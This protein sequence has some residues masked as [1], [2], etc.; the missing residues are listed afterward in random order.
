MHTAS[1]SLFLSLSPHH[2]LHTPFTSPSPCTSSEMSS[3]ASQL[4]A[5]TSQKSASRR[6]E[7]VVG[8]GFG[9]TA[10]GGGGSALVATESSAK[11]KATVVYQDAREASDVPTSLIRAKCYEALKKLGKLYRDP[12][13][14]SFGEL[15]ASPASLHTE[16]SLL[17]AAQ[18]AAID[19]K[20]SKLLSHLSTTLHDKLSLDV[21][22]YLIR[23]YDV[24]LRNGPELLLASLAVHDTFLFSRLL[25][26]VNVAES[27]LLFFLRPHAAPGAPPVPRGL[28]A[29][30]T[31]KDDALLN[32]ICML[33][34]GAADVHV[35]CQRGGDRGDDGD[36]DEHPDRARLQGGKPNLPRPTPPHISRVVSFAMAVVV[37]ALS[38][39]RS[40]PRASSSSSSSSSSPSVD[41]IS[42]STVRLLLPYLVDA[43]GP[44][45][46]STSCMD[47]RAFGYVLASELAG[48]GGSRG[49]GQQPALGSAGREL[50]T[51]A[52]LNGA[53]E[54]D[55][56][57]LS[58][59]REEDGKDGDESG[60]D[61]DK[62]E[63]IK[64]SLER[65]EV[66]SDAILAVMATLLQGP[67]QHNPADLLPLS[68]FRLLSKMR[69]LPAALGHIQSKGKVDVATFV[70]ALLCR[71]LGHLH[72]KQ[73]ARLAKLVEALTAVPELRRAVWSLPP[74]RS[75][76][77][78]SSEAADRLVRDLDSFFGSSKDADVEGDDA[79]P[80]LAVLRALRAVDPPGADAG[81]ARAV[82]EADGS[83]S[84]KTLAA[85]DAVVGG[86]AGSSAG[87]ASPSEQQGGA[88]PAGIPPRV[89]L[90]H[91]DSSVRRAAVESIVATLA[92]AAADE[93]AEGD[94]D[95]AQ[96]LLHRFTSDDDISVAIKAGAGYLEA[97]RSA[98]FQPP[99][100]ESCAVAMDKWG[101]AIETEQSHFKRSRMRKK[102]YGPKLAEAAKIAFAICATSMRAAGKGSR[103][104]A[105]LAE[106]LMSHLPCDFYG[107]DCYPFA[108][109]ENQDGPFA[110]AD[111]GDDLAG[112]AADAAANLRLG[113][114][115]EGEETA[116]S[117]VEACSSYMAGVEGKQLSPRC[118]YAILSDI[119]RGKKGK[120][121]QKSSISS[122]TTM[123]N[124]RQIILSLVCSDSPPSNPRLECLL[125]LFTSTEVEPSDAP[126]LIKSLLMVRGDSTVNVF[127]VPA[128][129]FILEQTSWGVLQL[130]ELATS[131]APDCY[132][133]AQRAAV[134][135]TSLLVKSK[136]ASSSSS[137][138]DGKKSTKK[139]SASAEDLSRAPAAVITVS[140]SAVIPAFSLLTHPE[141]IVR[142]SAILF[143][144]EFSSVSSIPEQ[145]ALL[146]NQACTGN[147]LELEIDMNALPRFM[148]L[149]FSGQGSKSLR[150][151]FLTM[152]KD[153]LL[154]G[155]ESSLA[156][157]SVSTM[158]KVIEVAG[159]G[160]DV[161]FPLNE[162]WELCGRFIWKAL[163][164]SSSSLPVTA[165]SLLRNIVRL[166]RGVAGDGSGSGSGITLAGK[167]GRARSYSVS[168]SSFVS[169]LPASMVSAYTESLDLRSN[170]AVRDEVITVMKKHS[171]AD[172]VFA[173]LDAPVRLAIASNLMTIR[174]KGALGNVE[175]AAKALE[176]LPLNCSEIISLIENV[177]LTKKSS[178]D[179]QL[180]SL[181]ILL[182]FVSS[183]ALGMITESVESSFVV[184]KLLF[185]KL[186]QLATNDLS[187]GGVDYVKT[188]LL[189]T[190]LT[191]MS[192]LPKFGAD[193]SSSGTPSKGEKRRRRSSSNLSAGSAG[194]KDK[195]G[196]GKEFAAYAQL[197]VNMVGGT[198]VIA[199][200]SASGCQCALSLLTV[201]CGLSPATVA[202]SLLPALQIV[203]VQ[204]EKVEDVRSFQIMNDALMAVVPSYCTNAKSAELSLMDLMRNFVDFHDEIS[205]HR[206]SGLFAGLMSAMM[207]VKKFVA[208]GPLIA[209]I[210]AF[211]SRSVVGGGAAVDKETDH[212]R[213]FCLSLIQRSPTSEQVSRFI[214]VVLFLF[215]FFVEL[216]HRVVAMMTF[217]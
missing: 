176:N 207:R 197:L 103:Q 204:G 209:T 161:V 48:G 53:S 149:A 86:P 132:Q 198:D 100:A 41:G 44:S 77:S 113:G 155:I 66:A 136:T 63:K 121:G 168:E 104:A 170:S 216:L 127:S 84:P 192:S 130:L 142:K 147:A 17:T 206:R 106:R 119:A 35:A 42:E 116:E 201:L 85:L 67:P 88:I 217:L 80:F 8:R 19:Q 134:L 28:L 213:G 180:L 167:N 49:G 14:S 141:R 110:E 21:L 101:L 59:A 93:N 188:T 144:E 154:N 177:D 40:D 91:P 11:F 156:F 5:L 158:L 138:G 214:S 125:K 183:A 13:L 210:L 145:I 3:L 1:L 37:D 70:R 31:G 60:K 74:S 26:V 172:N 152:I 2:T 174:T 52:M 163:V 95:L 215:F 33:A 105:D 211:H 12:V 107:V 72:T 7:D 169:P 71:A 78:P 153:N 87:P 189:S 99:D 148:A 120:K 81:V 187:D 114:E 83:L 175:S 150:N 139:R 79:K 29:K 151:V 181:T 115:G 194:D 137:D 32:K 23:R 112:V 18:N 205:S 27:Q 203:T 94:E 184:A 166:M 54:S 62:M 34:R 46:R 89:A 75:Q 118:T 45:E 90:E 159:G 123:F 47:Y 126:S 157:S 190:L 171:W 39:R 111:D 43:V 38:L 185:N 96:S 117:A 4:S 162:R 97:I 200:L 98:P 182:E 212:G 69:I 56:I 131:F 178:I 92:A 10:A 179:H 129:K 65:L 55:G 9:Y 20:V 30:Q 173:K 164:E 36:G 57:M 202:R 195:A 199:P 165:S 16:R 64:Y 61:D 143:V 196:V 135:A 24:H 160:E 102:K 128:I 51:V 82:K 133:A 146:A 76:P 108:A 73:G 191:L 208:V 68:T 50:V 186:S 122:G 140:A 22:E 124:S 15:I 6:H 25:Q 58:K 109:A 193:S